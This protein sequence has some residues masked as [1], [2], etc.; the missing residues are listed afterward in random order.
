MLML[1]LIGQYVHYL[2][3]VFIYAQSTNSQLNRFTNQA[4]RSCSFF[5]RDQTS[6]LLFCLLPRKTES[7]QILSWNFLKG[8]KVVSNPRPSQGTIDLTMRQSPQMN[9]RS[10]MKEMVGE[11]FVIWWIANLEF[12]WIYV[13]TGLLKAAPTTWY[14]SRYLSSVVVE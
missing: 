1:M 14:S 7:L 13:E 10:W 8:L 3:R 9:E 6:W 5:W 2:R 4:V 11:I 12:I